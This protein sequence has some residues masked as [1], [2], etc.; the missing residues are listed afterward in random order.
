M[1]GRHFS[2]SPLSR[3]ASSYGVDAP[4]IIAMPS[5]FFLTAASLSAAA[6]SVWILPMIARGV[7]AGIKNAN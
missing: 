5:N 2:V 4:A 7:F 3:A 1:T 6:V